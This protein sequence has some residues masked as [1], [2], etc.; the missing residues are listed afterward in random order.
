MPREGQ[1]FAL[2]NQSN[3]L[4]ELFSTQEQRDDAKR[5]K[6]VDVPLSEID[7][8]PNHPFKVQHDEAM[9]NMVESVKEVGIQTPAV[10]RQT[11]GGRYELISGHRRKMAAG[12]AGL[13]TLPVIVRMFSR[14][15]AIIAMV[16]ANLQRESLLPSE[17]AKSYK[18]RLDA[19]KRQAGR[20]NQDNYSPLANNL[21][22]STSSAELAEVLGTSKD[23]IFRFVRLTELIPDILQMVDDGKVAYRP[24]AELSYLT[25]EQQMDLL[26]TMQSEDS[27]PSLEQAQRMKRMSQEG[28]LNIDVIF[29]IL[30]EQKPNQKDQ[31]KIPRERIGKFFPDGTSVQKIE[32]TIVKALELLRKREQSREAR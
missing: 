23:T 31:L 7:D 25:Q 2:P 5:E 3:I 16:D 26:E 18:M 11:E 30:T 12:L 17:R 10:V 19:M 9:Q 28:R 24:A 32:E 27:T 22:G 4:G 15:E 8:F 6:V 20:P 21:S 14:D 13:K 29:T 1:T